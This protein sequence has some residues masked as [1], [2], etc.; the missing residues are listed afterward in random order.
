MNFAAPS[1][2]ASE[3]AIG[4][5]DL[6]GDGHIEWSG[7]RTGTNANGPHRNGDMSLAGP[8]SADRHDIA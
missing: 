1:S 8:G 4:T 2:P 6:D 7:Y 3:Q 5:T